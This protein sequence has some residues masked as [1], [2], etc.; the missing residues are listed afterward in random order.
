MKLRSKLAPRW[1]GP[2]VVT[3]ELDQLNYAVSKSSTSSAELIVNINRMKL[4]P[5]R[6]TDPT[7]NASFTSEKMDNSHSTDWKIKLLEKFSFEEVKPDLPESPYIREDSN[8]FPELAKNLV[9][10]EN[11]KHDPPFQPELDDVDTDSNK[12]NIDPNT[13]RSTKTKYNLR[14]KIKRP[15]RYAEEF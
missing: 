4:L 2:Y 5:I 7:Q 3:R 9:T 10:P 13:D 12:E 14:S 11:E 1:E 6:D 15:V 8:L